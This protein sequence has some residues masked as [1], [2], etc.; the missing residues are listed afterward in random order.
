MTILFNYKDSV[1]AETKIANKSM[2]F[3]PSA[4]NLAF[5]EKGQ[6]FILGRELKVFHI[7]L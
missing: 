7:H 4:F 5:I 6:V 1:D 2:G 3:D